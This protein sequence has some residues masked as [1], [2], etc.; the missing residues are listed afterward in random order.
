MEP[1]Y[2]NGLRDLQNVFI[3]TSFRYNEFFLNTLVSKSV[4][5]LKMRAF[6]SSTFSDTSFRYCLKAENS[7]CPSSLRMMTKPGK[8]KVKTQLQ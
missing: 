5:A 2:N 7:S 8:R 6:L 3:L 1:R 4:L